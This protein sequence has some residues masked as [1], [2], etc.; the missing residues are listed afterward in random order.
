[1]DAVTTKWPSRI[2]KA[3][4]FGAR[5]GRQSA[6]KLLKQPDGDGERLKALPQDT[7]DAMLRR[8]RFYAQAGWSRQEVETWSRAFHAASG[9]II[10]PVLEAQ[11]ESADGEAKEALARLVETHRAREID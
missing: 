2:E 7:W 11:I 4:S 9:E 5:D 10:L 6:E 8:A 3:R 1:M